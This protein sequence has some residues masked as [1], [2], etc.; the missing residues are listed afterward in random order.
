[1]FHFRD[2]YAIK[3][4]VQRLEYIS[5]CIIIFRF[6]KVKSR[7][8][9]LSSSPILS[10]FIKCSSEESSFI[11]TVSFGDNDCFFGNEN[12]E[13]P[14]RIR[15]KNNAQVCLMSLFSMNLFSIACD[16]YLCIYVS[17][18]LQSYYPL[19]FLKNFT[20]FTKSLCPKFYFRHNA[21]IGPITA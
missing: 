15:T 14:P 18:Q 4:N 10:L 3:I 16:Q 12:V 1:M 2:F 19:I 21:T 8:T 11:A 5:C 20:F 17:R 9:K 13:Q 7:A 6:E